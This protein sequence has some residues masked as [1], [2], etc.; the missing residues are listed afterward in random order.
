MDSTEAVLTANIHTIRDVQSKAEDPQIKVVRIYQPPNS[1]QRVLVWF[2]LCKGLW[3][4]GRISSVYS[5]AIKC[6]PGRYISL[7]R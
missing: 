3:K 7:L 6:I 1:L 4:G 2:M 5:T